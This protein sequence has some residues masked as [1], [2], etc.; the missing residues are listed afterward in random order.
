MAC[1][2]ERMLVECSA[3]APGICAVVHAGRVARYKS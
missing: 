3:G 1:F 2:A